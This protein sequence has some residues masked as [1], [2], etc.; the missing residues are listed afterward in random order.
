MTPL[1][2]TVAVDVELAKIARPQHLPEGAEALSQNLLP[3]R[4]K[5]Q[6]RVAIPSHRRL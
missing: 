4:N 3:V 5:Q 6:A 1:I 2:G